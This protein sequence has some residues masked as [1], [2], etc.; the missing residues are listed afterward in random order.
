MRDESTNPYTPTE[1]R[2]AWTQ[3]IH[4]TNYRM[5]ERTRFQTAESAERQAAKR[6]SEPC[7]I[8]VDGSKPNEHREQEDDRQALRDDAATLAAIQAWTPDRL[9]AAIKHGV[10]VACLPDVMLSP[11][12]AAP[13]RWKA[14]T[15]GVVEACDWYLRQQPERAKQ[16]AKLSA[17]ASTLDDADTATG[18]TKKKD[19]SA[20]LDF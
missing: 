12:R 3:Q 2:A 4:G 20:G 19:D 16:L 7:A 11:D 17:A 9:T 15:R 8:P 13:H 10:T 5:A 6:G 18:T 14:H 1:Y